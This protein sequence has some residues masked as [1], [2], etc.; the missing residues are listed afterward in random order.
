MFEVANKIVEVLF[1]GKSF[2]IMATSLITKE[3]GT[4]ALKHESI[5]GRGFKLEDLLPSVEEYR[6][7]AKDI[8][9]KQ[10]AAP[11]TPPEADKTAN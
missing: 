10:T 4:E 9:A 8:I 5:I 7:L 1:S 2:M 6:K 3:D 11:A